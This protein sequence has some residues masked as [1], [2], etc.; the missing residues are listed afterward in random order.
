MKAR[1]AYSKAVKGANGDFQKNMCEHLKRLLKYPKTSLKKMNVGKA[2]KQG[3]NL[4]QVYDEEGVVRSGE[5]HWNYGE[6]VLL[7]SWGGD[8]HS[9][10]AVDLSECRQHLCE[11][12]SKEVLEISWALNV[13]KKDA[14]PG[15][16]G[17]VIHGNDADK[18]A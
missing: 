11:P 7:G 16:D 4:L 10:E 18:V 13:V 17:V 15:L 14:A 6:R 5:R 1:S 2:R 12:I 8:T 9:R 3:H